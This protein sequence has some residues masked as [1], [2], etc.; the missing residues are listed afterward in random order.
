M[1]VRVLPFGILKDWLGGSTLELPEDGTVRTLLDQL[2]A[3]RA[4]IP[5]ST[6]SSI[7]VSVNHE[8]AH[9]AHVLSEGDEVGLLPP[10]SGG[11]GAVPQPESYTGQ[12]AI[13]RE[14]IDA[15]PLLAAAKHG[16]DGAVVVFDGIV[17]NNT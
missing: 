4:T 2:T 16:Q 7:A 11:S 5:A 15:A 9:P 6:W 14:P 13:V 10:V 12:I 17:R 8:Y 3:Q 1:Q